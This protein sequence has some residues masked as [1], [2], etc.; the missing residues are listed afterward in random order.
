M[1]QKKI[2]WLALTAF[3]LLAE[4]AWAETIARRGQ[5]EFTTEDFFALHYMNAP[6][7][8]EALKGISR[9]VQNS[10]IEVL[11]A[12]SYKVTPDVRAKLDDAEQRY[13]AL[14]L[15]RAPLS[16]ELN[17][18]ERRARAAFKPDD[19][20]VLARA[21]EIWLADTTRFMADE[22]AD[23][24]QMMFD[25]SGRKFAE[26]SERIKLAQSD[27]AKGES[28]DD[29][30]KKYTDDTNYK[31]TSGKL[32]GLSIARA[33]GLMGHLIFSQLKEGEV[34]AP[35][36]TRTGLHIVRLD[37]KYLK[38]KKPFDEVKGAILEQMLEDSAKAARLELVDQLNK[39]ETVVDEKVFDEFVG[40]A[41]PALEERRREVYRSLGINVSEPLPKS[42]PTP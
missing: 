7:K 42:K 20:I 36:P 25:L 40:K 16:A 38:A 35:T 3:T 17:V 2:I 14:Q 30:V 23:I 8:V 10:I 31:D 5:L 41:D 37:K 39:V 18:R 28:F 19:P 9:E 1:N 13:F 15:E 33:D 22:T 12:R 26:V 6:S 29:V 4:N 34:S 32:K 24:T 11:A 21:K 27:L